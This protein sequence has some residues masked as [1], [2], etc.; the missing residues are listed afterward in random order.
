M[1]VL[2]PAN[3]DGFSDEVEP[4]LAREGG[5]VL[6]THLRRERSK[7]LIVRFKGSLKSLSCTVCGFDFAQTYGD[8]GAGFI[9]AHHVVPLSQLAP[10][11]RTQVQDLVAVC[12]NCHRMLHRSLQLSVDELKRRLGSSISKKT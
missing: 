4:Y 9:E 5:A 3:A 10:G 8:V 1:D 2:N 7:Q 11:S 6:K 12:S